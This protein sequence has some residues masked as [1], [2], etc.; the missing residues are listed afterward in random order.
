M[1]LKQWPTNKTASYEDVMTPVRKVLDVILKRGKDSTETISYDG[2]GFFS[3][4]ILACLPN[5]DEM[6]HHD[7]LEYNKEHGRDALDALLHVTYLLGT[8]SGRLQERFDEGRL[9]RIK[10]IEMELGNAQT[11]LRELLIENKDEREN[12]DVSMEDEVKRA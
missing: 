10:L 7:G 9:T 1:T 3:P 12:A 2:Y 11:L 6:F 4:Q 5:A 8:E